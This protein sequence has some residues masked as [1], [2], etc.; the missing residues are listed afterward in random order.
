[1]SADNKKKDAKA[2][3]FSPW[4]EQ[5]E[6]MMNA[7]KDVMKNAKM[8]NMD[9][10]KLLASQQKN[11]EMLNE[12]NK[13]AVDVMKSI[14]QLQG[15]Y[16]RQAFDDM[17]NFIR[18]S[19]SMTPDQASMQYQGQK[20]QESIEKAVDHGKNVASMMTKSSQDMHERMKKRAEETLAE[21]KAATQ[22]K[23]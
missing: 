9:P 21:M 12:A 7:A 14:T 18:T 8:P 23:H 17:N 11:L 2:N 20:M 6:Q 19:M 15:Q 3:P 1:M 16:M 5:Q 4:Q 13:T 10:Q 22:A